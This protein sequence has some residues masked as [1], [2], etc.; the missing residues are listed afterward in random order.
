MKTSVSE[1]IPTN[2]YFPLRIHIIPQ[3]YWELLFWNC[4]L[5]WFQMAEHKS[6]RF[7]FFPPIKCTL[8]LHLV[9]LITKNLWQSENH[10]YYK[11]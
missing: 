4:P 2:G 8:S 7:H 5:N 10:P 11:G 6:Y 1:L 9:I 3:K